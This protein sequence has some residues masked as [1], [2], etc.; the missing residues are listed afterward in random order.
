VKKLT[1][2]SHQLLHE[3]KGRDGSG[4]GECRHR[5]H[6]ADSEVGLKVPIL[7]EHFF[8]F[9]PFFAIFDEKLDFQKKAFVGN[10][11]FL[12]FWTPCFLDTDFAMD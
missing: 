6:S 9:W 11:S 1:V 5:F 4:G 8:H 2:T 10:P 7:R 3:A 12:S